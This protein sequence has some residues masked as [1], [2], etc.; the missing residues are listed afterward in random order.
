[1]FNC[2]LLNYSSSAATRTTH[3]ESIT[4][5]N[6]SQWQKYFNVQ[7]V[8]NET[9]S[10]EISVSARALRSPNAYHGWFDSAASFQIHLTFLRLLKREVRW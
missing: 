7:S 10:L 6:I 5:E 4:R 2:L 9:S 1:M 8:G 3:E